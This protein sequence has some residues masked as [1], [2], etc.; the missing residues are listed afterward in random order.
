M[1]RD[2]VMCTLSWGSLHRAGIRK[3]CVGEKR[4]TE[5]I[6]YTHHQITMLTL[7]KNTA[8]LRAGVIPRQ[9]AVDCKC[10][11]YQV[12]ALTRPVSLMTSSSAVNSDSG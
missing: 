3:E 7:L 11:D 9:G 6:L 8:R 2:A 5:L 1:A 10:I 12:Q 4:F